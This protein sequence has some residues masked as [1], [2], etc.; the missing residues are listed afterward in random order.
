MK[1]KILGAAVAL[2][3]LAVSSQVGAA[4]GDLSYDELTNC[5]AFVLLEAQVYDGD[6][7]SSEDKAKAENYY[8]QAASLTVAASLLSKKDAKVVTEEVKGRNSKMIESLSQDGAAEKL[9]RDNAERCNA[10]GQAAQ[11]ALADKK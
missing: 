6:K 5:A 9:I 10:L 1:M 7:A 3:T 8:Q 2:S 11:E 4:D